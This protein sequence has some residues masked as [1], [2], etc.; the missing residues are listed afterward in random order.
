MKKTA[1]S[2]FVIIAFL[3]SYSS[4]QAQLK[5]LVPKKDLLGGLNDVSGL[6]F[7][8]KNKDDLKKHNEGFV[9]DIFNIMDGD[10]SEEDKRKSL[11]N[12]KNDSEKK[13]D[14]MLGKSGAKKYKKKMKKAMRPYTSKVKL[15]KLVI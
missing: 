12:L 2:I 10:D 3:F 1:T 4:A 8:D 6:G 13:L 15:L 9:N 14:K 5:D 7:S 11:I